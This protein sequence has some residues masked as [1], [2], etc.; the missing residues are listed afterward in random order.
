MDIASGKF[1]NGTRK[2][3]QRKATLLAVAFYLAADLLQGCTRLTKN[4]IL[5]SCAIGNL[6]ASLLNP[7][8]R[9]IE[10][11]HVITQQ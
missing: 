5:V 6:V 4:G 8:S 1:F 11:G 2:L 3:T 9:T 10:S 7:F